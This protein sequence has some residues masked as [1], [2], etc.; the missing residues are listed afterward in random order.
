VLGCSVRAEA[1]GRPAMVISA[2]TATV[3]DGVGRRPAS[4]GQLTNPIVPRA[5]VALM[6]NRSPQAF[7]PERKTAGMAGLS[8]VIPEPIGVEALERGED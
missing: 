3:S 6:A 5:V 4:P 1:G 2:P 7:V 8:G